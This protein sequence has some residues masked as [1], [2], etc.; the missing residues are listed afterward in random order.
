MHKSTILILLAFFS[1]YVFWGSTY[2]WNKIAVTELPAF[3]L[4]SIRFLT[5]GILVLVVAKILKKSLTISIKQL[6][7]IVIA[8]VLFLAFGNGAFVYALKF[9]DSGFAALEASISP[10]MILII[11][12]IYQKKPIKLRSLIG[13]ALGI[14]GMYILVSQNG[15]NLHEGSITGI[16]IIFACVL[17]WSIGSV[18]VSQAELP[19]N[20]FVS[21][22]YQM[23]SAGVLL[24]I[25]SVMVGDTWIS[26]KSW[27]MDTLISMLCLV[28]FGSIA[29]FTS[30]NY[31]LK[32]V[33]PEKVSTSGYVNPIIALLLGWYFLGESITL[34]TIIAG[35]LLLLGVY[36]INTRK[37]KR[38][39]KI[40]S[41][42]V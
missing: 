12:R 1:T 22:G 28:L 29:A 27:Q 11:M 17:S 30:F 35:C 4:A 37:E 6:R 41:R 32:K 10:L 20:F 13:I 8:S 15:L 38:R 36:F 16:L 33:S 3:M 23:L 34:Q 9:V 14:I 39:T 26:P 24:G 18:F 31:L 2:L 42:S 7:N 25:L 40:S 5:A 21:T 19:K